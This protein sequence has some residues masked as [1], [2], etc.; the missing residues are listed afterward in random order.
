MVYE[1]PTSLAAVSEGWGL[2]SAWFSS[3]ISSSQNLFPG[4][5]HCNRISVPISLHSD[6]LLRTVYGPSCTL[7]PEGPV[8]GQV[9]LTKQNM[10]LQLEKDNHHMVSFICGIYEIVKGTIKERRETE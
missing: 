3:F 9:L 5:M 7:I 8:K 10:D 2:T 1:D 6:R 4:Q